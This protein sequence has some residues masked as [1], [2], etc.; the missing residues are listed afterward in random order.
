MFDCESESSGL[1]TNETKTKNPE[2]KRSVEDFPQINE[3]DIDF[4]VQ[5]ANLFVNERYLH[6]FS[7]I[8]HDKHSNCE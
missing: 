6:K 8:F 2:L 7:V 1:A 3:I 4:T 5:G